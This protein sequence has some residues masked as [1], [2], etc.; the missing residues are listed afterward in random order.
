V[1][2]SRVV[3]DSPVVDGVEEVDNVVV[4]VAIF[5]HVNR[6]FS[7][8]VQKSWRTFS[9]HVRNDELDIE[10]T[11]ALNLNPFNRRSSATKF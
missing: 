7:F 1:V 9:A 4:S 8:L 10:T 3:L 6:P 11:V 2:D 5:E